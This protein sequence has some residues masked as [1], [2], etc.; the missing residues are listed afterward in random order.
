MESNGYIKLYRSILNSQVF[1]HQTAL[2]MWIWCLAKA[3][4]KERFIPLKIGKG[5]TTVTI[6]SGQFIF[7]RSVAEEE[8]GIDGSTI[9]K[10]MQKF[11]S[12]AFDNM[13]SLESN[14][15]YT[16]VTVNNWE[17]YQSKD[18]TEVTTKEQPRNNQVTAE[19]QPSSSSVTHTR[20]VKKSIESKEESVKRFSPPSIE[21]VRNYIHEKGYKVDAER[22]VAYYTSNGWKVGKNKMK[23]WKAAVLSWDRKNGQTPTGI[24]AS[25]RPLSPSIRVNE[26]RKNREEIDYEN[27]K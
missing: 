17:C 9:Y 5:I 16:V 14:N 20:R 10:W 7:G 3:S 6:K 13:I 27:A 26:L 18:E 21:E 15:Q 1:A 12:E 25:N 8:L 11:A 23:D 22:F 24:F 2:K 4:Y 19:E